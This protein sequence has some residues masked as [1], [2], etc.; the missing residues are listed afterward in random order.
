MALVLLT[1]LNIC[2]CSQESPLGKATAS[3]FND[4][5]QVKQTSYTAW[6]TARDEG[7]RASM[8]KSS[9]HLQKAI[10][11]ADV[12]PEKAAPDAFAAWWYNLAAQYWIENAAQKPGGE[13]FVTP[14]EG[15]IKARQ[16]LQ[17]AL[18]WD[19]EMA[20]RLE[21]EAYRIMESYK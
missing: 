17:K 1:G 16:D 12:T 4:E 3:L 20:D 9:D 13:V 21:R 6:K 7:P 19:G 8:K 2:A 15:I 10:A 11:S 14:I 18:G 5:P